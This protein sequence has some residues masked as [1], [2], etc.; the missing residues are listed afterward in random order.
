ME[1][2][3]GEG[4]GGFYGYGYTTQGMKALGGSV[5]VFLCLVF[6]HCMHQHTQWFLFCSSFCSWCCVLSCVLI[7]VWFIYLYPFIVSLIVT[8]MPIIALVEAFKT[9]RWLPAWCSFLGTL[10]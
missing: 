4:W 7:S 8:Q 10:S 2:G 9:L 1:K 5:G 3:L 6:W